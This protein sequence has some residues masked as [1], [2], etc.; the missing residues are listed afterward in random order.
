MEKE[1]EN[2]TEKGLLNRREFLRIA[3][4]AG[5]TVGLGAGLGGLIAACGG[6]E[7]TTTTTAAA[8][9][10][11]T[12]APASTTTTG[13]ASTTTVSAAA[14]V[15]R[16]V[17]VGVIIPITG[18]LALFGV[19]DKW[20]LGLVSKYLGDSFVLGDGKMH[21]VTWLLRDT[22]SD[23]NRAAQVTSDLY[24]NDK[25]DISCV[26]GGPDTV[27]PSADMAEASEQHMGGI[28][29]RARH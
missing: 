21:K 19:S 23:S 25:V 6:T 13:A 26:A 16:E 7:E 29:L 10:S 4:V 27:N 11:T 3:G 28:C 24:L 17:K 18:Y 15:G 12:A 2:R 14:E 8:A 9:P 1:T 22:Q 5:A 20:S